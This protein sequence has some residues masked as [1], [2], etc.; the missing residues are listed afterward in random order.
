MN[1]KFVKHIG[2]WL[3]AVSIFFACGKGKEEVKVTRLGLSETELTLRKGDVHS[4]S[5]VIAP[6]SASDRSV[7]WSSSKDEIV[8][9]AEGLV[10]AVAEGRAKV[11]ATTADSRKKA[12][13]EVTVVPEYI[14][15]ESVLIMDDSESNILS[16]T[17]IELY[18]GDVIALVAGFRPENVTNRNVSWSSSD[19][20]VASVKDGLVKALSEGTARVSIVSDAGM[21]TASCTIRVTTYIPP[22]A[23]TGV[24]LS[25]SLVMLAKGKTFLLEASVLPADAAN[26]GL[27]WSSSDANTASVDQSGLVTAVANGTAVISVRTKDGGFTANSTVVVTDSAAGTLLPKNGWKMIYA[28]SELGENYAAQNFVREDDPSSSMTGYA[29]DLIDGSY[30]SIWAYNWRTADP[31]PYYFVIDLGATYTI[32]ALDIWAQRGNKNLSDPTN[33]SS[34][35]QCGEATV[36]FAATLSGNGMGDLGGSGSANWSGKQTFTSG[37]LLNQI[38]NVICLSNPTSARYIRF[39]YVKGYKDTDNDEPT[40]TTGGSLAELDIIGY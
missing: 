18:T 8:T 9:V 16:G 35:R 33:T 28:S 34:T 39:C 11:Y 23:V 13:C 2:I 29:K 40:L 12:V 30:A 21:K 37:Q 25:P 22:V 26:K 1:N 5:V 17:T 31:T 32:T 38:H 15:V 20:G 7:V 27:V 36:E 4:L 3:L 19:T 10:T 24:T 6:S 14:P